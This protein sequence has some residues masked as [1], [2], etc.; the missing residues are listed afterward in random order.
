MKKTITFVFSILIAIQLQAQISVLGGVSTFSADKWDE[1]MDIPFNGISG[2][3]SL[4][5]LGLGTFYGLTYSIPIPN[6]GMRLLPELNYSSFKSIGYENFRLSNQERLDIEISVQNIAFLLNTN[7]YLFNLEGDCDCPTFGKEGGFFKKGFHIQAGPG[8][9]YSSKKIDETAADSG[10]QTVSTTDNFNF[11]FVVGAGL[12]IGLT[13]KF[14]ITP[15]ARFKYLASQE[16]IKLND[17]L[18]GAEEPVDNNS[19]SITNLEAGLKFGF[20]YKN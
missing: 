6:V 17:S 2:R 5:P 11:A 3:G 14:T 19:S 13:D 4:E 18:N 12:D 16:W 20:R 15:F 9:V 1:M 7:I 8:V 10:M